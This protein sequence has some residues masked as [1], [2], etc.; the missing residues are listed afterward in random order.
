MFSRPIVRICFLLCLSFIAV[1]SAALAQGNVNNFAVE[2][3]RAIKM[4]NEGKYVESLPLFEKLAVDKQADAE[5][6]FGLGIATLSKA[7]TIKDTAGRKQLRVK[8]RETLLKAKSLSGENSQIDSVLNTIK[9]DGGERGKSDNP[10]AN[11]AMEVAFAAFAERNYLKAA[12]LYEKAARLDPVL[13]EAALYTGNSF[14]GAK[15]HDKAGIWFAKAIALDPNRETAYRYWGDSLMVSGK[16]NEAKDKFFDAIVA[17]PYSQLAW[18]GLIQFARANNLKLA[19]PKIDIPTNISSNEKGDRTTITLDESLLK[20]T[21]DGSG[22]WMAY[23]LIRAV[24]RNGD[25]LK[26]FPNE[27]VYRHSLAEEAAALRGVLVAVKN[28]R[29][30]IKQLNPALKQLQELNDA[31]LLEAYILLAQSDAGI[32]QDYDAYRQ[33]NRDKLKRYLVEFLIIENGSSNEKK[34]VS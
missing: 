2:R 20:E 12:E 33:N 19:H 29:K 8:A 22:A 28:Q 24:W 21:G 25:F 9:P 5:V 11:K 17:E 1:S 34:V 3:E 10:E 31:G 15:E 6:F 16:E 18:R 4:I 26:K 14:Y 30:D 23:G 32:R 7:D 13:Y 27:K